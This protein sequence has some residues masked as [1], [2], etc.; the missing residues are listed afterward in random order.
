MTFALS[1]G[2]MDAGLNGLQSV[3]DGKLAMVI[4]EEVDP[5]VSKQTVLL[6]LY[7]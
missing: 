6:N 5:R 2:Q 1:F 4:A 7:W 3:V